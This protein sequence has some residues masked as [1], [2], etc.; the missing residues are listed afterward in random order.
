MTLHTVVTWYKSPKKFV[1]A[2]RLPACM[3]QIPSLN[4]PFLPIRPSNCLPLKWLICSDET[5]DS[6]LH[7]SLVLT[8]CGLLWAHLFVLHCAPFIPSD[9]PPHNWLNRS[10]GVISQT[11]VT[12]LRSLTYSNHSVRLFYTD[13]HINRKK[14]SADHQEHSH[15][16][17]LPSFPPSPGTWTLW[18]TLL[19]CRYLDIW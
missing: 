13:H 17:I 12:A 7:Y 1:T 14:P 4:S 3:Y 2:L 15:Y 16:E 5:D 6:Y 18:S 11:R 19:T 9:S 10:V 8:L